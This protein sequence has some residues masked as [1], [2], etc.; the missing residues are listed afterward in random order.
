MIQ[1]NL[2]RFES[3]ELMRR[4]ANLKPDKLIGGAKKMGAKLGGKPFLVIGQGKI[5][6]YSLK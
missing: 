6:A 1:P 4:G 5:L 2:E 3:K